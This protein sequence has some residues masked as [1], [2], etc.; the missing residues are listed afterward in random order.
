MNESVKKGFIKGLDGLL[1]SG[2]VSGKNVPFWEILNQLID[3]VPSEHEGIGNIVFSGK[4][5][6]WMT[7]QTVTDE[8]SSVEVSIHEEQS[9]FENLNEI[10]SLRDAVNFLRLL[11]IK[12][13]VSLRVDYRID[14][15]TNERCP[16]YHKCIFLDVTAGGESC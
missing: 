16:N 14:P 10:D 12:N 7:G 6:C 11:L 4:L 1:E 2:C 3:A 13:V 8:M 15:E 5:A 9:V